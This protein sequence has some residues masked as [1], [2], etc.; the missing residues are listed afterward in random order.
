MEDIKGLEKNWQT[1]KDV[2]EDE[3]HCLLSRINE[4]KGTHY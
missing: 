4:M 1:E 3:K 2:L